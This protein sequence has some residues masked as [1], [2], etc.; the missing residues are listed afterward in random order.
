MSLK[1]LINK[2]KKEGV[3][4][5]ANSNE[6]VTTNGKDVYEIDLLEGI[7]K[8]TVEGYVKTLNCIDGL[9][10]CMHKDR[11]K[12]LLAKSNE[13]SSFTIGNEILKHRACMINFNERLNDIMEHSLK[14]EEALN[15]GFGK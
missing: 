6:E 11:Y 4:S 15:F 9:A 13:S 1:K 2:S 5:D 3:N 12:H 14:W 10:M 8:A 7:G